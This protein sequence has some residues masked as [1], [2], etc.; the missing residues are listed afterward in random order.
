[1]TGDW[2]IPDWPLP[3]GVRS[4]VT[5]RH[6]GV[7]GGACDSLNLGDHVGDDPRAVAENRARLA[8]HLPAAPVW[9]RQVHGTGVVELPLSATAE[10]PCADAAFTRHAGVV[11]AVLTADCL[12]VL[13]CDR[14][15]SVVAAAHAGWRGLLAGVLEST[16]AAMRCPAGQLLAYL[17]PAIGPRAFEVGAEVRAAFVGQRAE[18]DEAFQALHSGKWL[19]DLYLL[20]RRRLSDAGVDAVFGGG[21]CTFRDPDRFFSYRRDPA[22]GRMASLIWIDG[23]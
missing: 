7:S 17:G 9:L 10:A 13:L 16:V 23:R 4:L 6:G 19:A 14:G 1:M 3:P 2:I 22:A 15:G 21:Y 5:T 12:P 8:R 18:A 20:A 11:C